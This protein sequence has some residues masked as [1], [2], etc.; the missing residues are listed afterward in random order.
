[1]AGFSSLACRVVEEARSKV[2]EVAGE[3]EVVDRVRI[4]GSRGRLMVLVAG[5]MRRGREV[6]VG[7]GRR[8]CDCECMCIWHGAIDG[9]DAQNG[10]RMQEGAGIAMYYCFESCYHLMTPWPTGRRDVWR[11]LTCNCKKSEK[12]CKSCG[13]IFGYQIIY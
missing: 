5:G 4:R 10:I 8:V 11:G 2:A 1:M 7:E 3:G 9:C 13:S 6:V 12:W